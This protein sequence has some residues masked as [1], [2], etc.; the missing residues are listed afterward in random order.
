[1]E[2]GTRILVVNNEEDLQSVLTQVLS[3]D[4]HEVTQAATGEQALEVFREGDYHL[5]IT[6]MQMPGMSGIELLKEL[7]S[8]NPD[9]QVIIMTS[10]ASIDDAIKALRLGAYDYLVK[11]FENVDHVSALANH[12]IEKV[13]LSLKTQMLIDNLQRKNDDLEK[14]NEQLR[15]LAI[16]D[17]L[18]GIFN[19]MYFHEALEMEVLRSRRHKR[20]FSL[21]MLDVDLFK[22]YNDT[23]GH[24]EGDELLRLLAQLFTKRLRGSDLVAR[25]GGEEFAFILTETK[26]DGAL[27]VAEGIR[28]QIENHPFYGRNSQPSGKI[29]VSIGV[30]AYPDNGEDSSALLKYADDALYLAKK[31]GRNRVCH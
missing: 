22:N 13:L 14:A 23:H 24:P 6:D 10:F 25:Y 7:K 21:M 11:P 1:M 26:R 18:T 19:H 4:G 27:I 29:T 12:A 30:A 8:I 28:E 2:K 3:E 9:I 17:G 20:T 15:E 16:R 5:V 31:E